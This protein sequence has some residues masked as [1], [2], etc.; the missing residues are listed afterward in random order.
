MFS[1]MGDYRAS[2]PNSNVWILKLTS[3]SWVVGGMVGFRQADLDE[4]QYTSATWKQ[5]KQLHVLVR[6]HWQLSQYVHL[7]VHLHLFIHIYIYIY[8]FNH[9]FSIYV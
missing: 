4:T 7:R 5:W 3:T 2:D 1:Y 6:L 8:S 9:F